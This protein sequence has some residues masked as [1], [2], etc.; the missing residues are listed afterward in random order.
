M[1]KKHA[2][3]P[4]EKRLTVCRLRRP[5]GSP[6]PERALDGGGSPGGISMRLSMVG[7][8]RCPPPDAHRRIRRI[9]PTTGKRF[10]IVARAAASRIAPWPRWT[11]SSCAGMSRTSSAAFAPLV[12]ALFPADD[13]V[14]EVPG[15]GRS[16]AQAG[17]GHAGVPRTI[18]ASTFRTLACPDSATEGGPLLPV[19]RWRRA[20]GEDRCTS[21]AVRDGE[22]GW[23]RHGVPGPRAA[24]H[25]SPNFMVGPFSSGRPEIRAV[26][27][28]AAF[29][30]LPRTSR[31][32]AQAVG[33]PVRPRRRL[34]PPRN[35]GPDC[36]H[37]VSARNFIEICKQ[38]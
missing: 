9:P 5:E 8:P 31:R 22:G 18:P 24:P 15:P 19:R 37:I 20:G 32:A 30:R 36:G 16:Q 33:E 4:P 13:A 29:R 25:V 10:R 17:R 7:L 21:L 11:A 6:G 12:E 34:R 1:L 2:T 35:R 38:I 27:G 28:P 26:D 14:E 23:S 3:R